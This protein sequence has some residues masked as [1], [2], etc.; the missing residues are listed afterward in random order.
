[1]YRLVEL[2]GARL[3]DESL[4]DLGPERTGRTWGAYETRE[5]AEAARHRMERGSPLG[6]P[7]MVEDQEDDRGN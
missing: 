3:I 5:L 4:R 6:L 7:I 2:S 1:M